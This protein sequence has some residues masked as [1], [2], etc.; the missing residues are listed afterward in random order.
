MRGQPTTLTPVSNGGAHAVPMQLAATSPRLH[1]WSGC[2]FDANARLKL[3]KGYYVG[4][5]AAKVMA[6]RRADRK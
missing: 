3:T 5:G 4:T 2:S 6:L 1:R